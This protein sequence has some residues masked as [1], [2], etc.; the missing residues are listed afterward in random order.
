[1]AG[2]TRAT[3][4]SRCAIIVTV[5]LPIPFEMVEK[6]KGTLSDDQDI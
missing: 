4:A 2:N 1:M 3:T 6:E 5:I